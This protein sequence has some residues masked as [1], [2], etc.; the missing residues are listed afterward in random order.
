MPT[1]F[2]DSENCSGHIFP[3]DWREDLHDN[4]RGLMDLNRIGGNRYKFKAAHPRSD[5][6]DYCNSPEGAVPWQLD[7]VGNYGCICQ[8]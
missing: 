7:H 2:V 1:G 8:N 4:I 3:S 6:M 5:F